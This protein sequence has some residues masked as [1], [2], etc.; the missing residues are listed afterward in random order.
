MVHGML[1][2]MNQIHG[3]SV[4]KLRRS[5]VHVG[6]SVSQVDID[7][8]C[9]RGIMKACSGMEEVVATEQGS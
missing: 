5:S 7:M 8:E 6:C 3:C 1:K 2:Y 9:N 4:M